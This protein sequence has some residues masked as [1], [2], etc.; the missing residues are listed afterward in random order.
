MKIV[1]LSSSDI[2]GG[3]ALAAHRLHSGLRRDGVDSWMIVGRKFS[4]DPYVLR[5]PSALEME[6]CERLDRQPRRFLKTKNQSHISSG[7]AGCSAWKHANRQ[8]ADLTHLHWINKGFVR[9]EAVPKLR[10]PL[11]WSLHDMWAFAGGEHYF[12]D[13]VR[14]RRAISRTTG[15]RSNPASI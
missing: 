9:V 11:V 14:Y 15:R 12:D 8:R 3:A 7:W 13:C 6:I 5:P 1:H 10:G 2:G 4:Q